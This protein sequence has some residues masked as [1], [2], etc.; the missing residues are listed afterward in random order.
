MLMTITGMLGSGK[1]TV[2]G[3]MKNSY[4]FEVFSTGTIQRQYA[5][6]LG[7]DTLEL[8]KRMKENPQ[9]DREIDDLVAK[10]ALER[11]NDRLIFDSRLAWHF[12][13]KS[14]KV[15]LTIDPTEAGRRVYENRRSSEETY[16]DAQ[17]A[18]EKL[19]ERGLVERNRFIEIY[20]VDYF[21]HNNYNIIVDTTSKTPDEVVSII[22]HN[23]DV[24]TSNPDGFGTTKEF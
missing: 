12:A 2:C 16:K 1:S 6:K 8:N 14:F 7:I 3:I 11:I 19:T 22:M 9:L 18:C 10:V 15:F 13:G 4:G 24:Y 5:N 23:Y 21:D 17:E 20:G